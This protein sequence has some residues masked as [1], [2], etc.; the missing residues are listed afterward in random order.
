M[1]EALRVEDVHTYYGDSYVLQGVSLRV[2][3][4]QLVAVLGRNGVGKTTLIRSVVG[5]TPPRSGR[6]R[7]RGTDITHLPSH[8][9][10]RMG[11]G[12]VPQGRRIFPS[13]TVEENLVVAARPDSGDAWTLGRVYELFPRLRE[14]AHHRGNKLSGGEQ[15]MLAIAR[16]LMTNPKLLLMDEP[17]EGLAPKLVLDLAETLVQ[18][19]E[20]G[21]S[22]LMVE[23]NLPL[24]L[25]LADY[26]YVMSKG[27]V[28]FEGTPDEVRRAEAVRQR[29]L[30]V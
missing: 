29:Y 16:A 3:P 20:R 24:A 23:Q 1:T 4:G 7:F 10:A 5:F 13:L 17:S 25:R 8:V 27:T 12:L 9:I 26:V 11:V 28:V 2:A 30:G 6:I 19:K 21:L 18:L 14:R 22:I 15:Q